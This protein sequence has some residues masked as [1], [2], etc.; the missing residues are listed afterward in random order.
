MLAIGKSVPLVSFPPVWL[1]A[2]KLSVPAVKLNVP[3]ALRLMLP[4]L[5]VPPFRL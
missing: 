4:A 3:P 1:N 5:S 2:V